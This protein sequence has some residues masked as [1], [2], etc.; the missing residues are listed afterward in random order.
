[1]VSVMFYLEGKLCPPFDFARQDATVNGQQNSRA[2]VFLKNKQISSYKREKFFVTME[3]I[4]N[5]LKCLQLI[6][7]Q[8]M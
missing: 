1:M 3:L 5:Q 4:E 7:E 2:G 6:R 8:Q